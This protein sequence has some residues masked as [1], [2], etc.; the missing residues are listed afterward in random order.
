MR[1]L[2]LT[3]FLLVPAGAFAQS[4]AAASYCN[5]VTEQAAAQRDLLRSPSLLAGPTQPSTGTPPQL[6]F[7][8][9][10]SLSDIEKSRLVMKVAKTNCALYKATN[11]TQMHL[12]YALP[13]LEKEILRHRLELIQATSDKL[14]SLL[15]EN[16]KLV[17]AQNLARPALYPLEGAKVRLDTSRTAALTGMA[18]PYVP[19]L[20]DTPLK[21]LIADKMEKESANLQAS[22]KLEKQG[23]WD[24]KLGGGTHRQITS[25]V[26][27]AVSSVGAYG[28][29]S[30]TYNLGRRAI[31]RHIDQ[32][33]SA[34]ADWKR[35]QFDDVAYQGEILKHQIMDTLETEK[36]QLVVLHNHGQEIEAD[37]RTLEGVDTSNAIAFRNQLI[38]DQ[39]VLRVEIGDLEFRMVKLREFLDRNF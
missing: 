35:T 22:N 31:N 30:V 27:P 11:E 17:E 25:L 14:D 26:G 16:M 29:F 18:S 38:S 12:I 15:L 5:Y 10:D 33:E 34:Y 7:G 32:S 37:L 20:S 13:A 21:V 1:A 3:A 4:E 19:P 2:I 36:T 8:I 6:V 28:E 23:T 9:S 24:I 39:M